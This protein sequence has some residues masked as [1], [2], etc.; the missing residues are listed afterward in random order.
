MKTTNLIDRHEKITR[1]LQAEDSSIRLRAA[2]AAGSDPDPALLDALVRRCAVEPDF[3]V[4]DMLSWAI[5]RLPA[6]ITLPAL[7]AELGSPRTQARSQALHTLSKVGD[8][9][10]WPWITRDMLAGPDDEVARTAWRVASSLVPDREKK[11][12]AEV[13]ASQLGRGDHGTQSSLSRSLVSLGDV[14]EPILVVAAMS[15]D[16]T[17]A[18]HAAATRVLLHD[19]EAGFAGAIDEARRTVLM[20]PQHA[21]EA[22]AVVASRAVDG[23]P[24]APEG[25]D[26]Q[27]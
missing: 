3:Y 19:P 14:I 4:R 11:N 25:A 22:A 16:H 9:R 18:A 1:A 5:I 17:V 15:S 7:R 8:A 13:L 24:T 10:A 21:A 12:L 23:P 26:G 2:M 27:C 20:G 6:D